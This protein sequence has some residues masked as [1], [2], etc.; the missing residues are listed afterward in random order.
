MRHNDNA[1]RASC[2]SCHWHGIPSARRARETC[3]R[4]GGATFLQVGTYALVP[5]RG[6]GR[7]R[8][9][10]AVRTYAREGAADRAARVAYDE[11]DPRGLVVRFITRETN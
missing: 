4:C 9:E 10:Q 7:Y 3:P 6:D 2:M 8:L 5:W 11:G 1:R